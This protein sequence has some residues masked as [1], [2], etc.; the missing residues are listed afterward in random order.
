MRLCPLAQGADDQIQRRRQPLLELVEALASLEAHV[1]HKA[2]CRTTKSED[3]ADDAAPVFRYTSQA[4]NSQQTTLAT[5]NGPASS[6]V[7]LREQIAQLGRDLQF[8]RSRLRRE[9]C[10]AL[11]VPDVDLVVG[12]VRFQQHRV[13][14]GRDLLLRLRVRRTCLRAGPANSDK[15]RDKYQYGEYHDQPP[16]FRKPQAT[17]MDVSNSSAASVTPATRSLSRNFGRMPLGL[18]V[19]ITFR[20]VRCPF[21]RS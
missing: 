5:P 19:P 13:Q 18:N 15:Y 8:A 2:P 6:L 4:G 9:W 11:P 16:P 20:S 7:G 21:A 17:S 3:E 1:T 14:T 10:S 12:F